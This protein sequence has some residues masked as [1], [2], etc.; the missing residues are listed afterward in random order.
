MDI[1]WMH[2]RLA[3]KKFGHPAAIGR[4]RLKKVKRNKP[5]T[6][7]NLFEKMGNQE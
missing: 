3:L 4:I 2:F 1:A 6:T 5:N 7:K